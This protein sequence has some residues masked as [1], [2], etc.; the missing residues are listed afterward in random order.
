MATVLSNN[1]PS[2][3]EILRDR[4]AEENLDLIERVDE[5]AG[6]AERC[7]VTDD[8]TAGKAALLVK[9][10]NE[11]TK[12]A[13]DRQKEAKRP[14]A[15]LADAAFGYFKPMLGNL[16]NAKTSTLAKLDRYRQEQERKA[17]EE[18]RRLE[19]EARKRQEEADRIAAMAKTETDIDLAVEV[20]QQARQAAEQAATVAPKEIRSNYGHLA[21]ARKTWDYRIID[22][23]QV[24]S[25]YMMV[26]EA[27]IKVAIKGGA[28]KIPGVEIFEK[29][30][31]V[32][33]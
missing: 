5:L 14:H 8:D 9:L 6:G 30:V 15:E 27:A 22:P 12:T 25:A 31:T 4:L 7:A 16:A 32:V 18:R 2:D 23:S 13:T 24:P 19:E 28:R 1:P 20:E 33:R 11:T 26:N 17:A 10:I 3:V 29:T 21:S